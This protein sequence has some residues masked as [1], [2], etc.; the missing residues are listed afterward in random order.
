[1]P[2]FMARPLA[3]SPKDLEGA[4]VVI[5]GSSYVAGSEEYAG[6]SRADWMAAAKRVRQQS[7]RYLSG[8]VQEFDI[9]IFEHLKVVDYGDAE[10]PASCLEELTADN[11]LEAQAAVEQ[12]VNDVLAAGAIPIVIGQN[13]PCS[14][15]AIAKPISESTAGKVGMV[16]LDTHWDSEPI[17]DLTGDPRIAGSA[18]WKLK[19]YQNLDNFEPK[20][21][22]EIGERGMLEN[23]QQV[24]SYLKQGVN[25]YP[26]WKIR[27]ELGIEGLCEEIAHAY[28]DTEAVYV[29]FDMDVIG[30][31]GPVPGDIL[32][33]LA[34]PMGM[35]DY[36]VLRIANEVGRR[37]LTGMSF[38]CIPP[39]SNIVY[40]LITYII[41]FL[42]AGLLEGREEG[43]EKG[44]EE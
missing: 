22:V 9:D 43:R 24:R 39:G 14:S 31:A 18:N 19:T 21:L 10:V 27:R 16:S 6:V 41:M 13:S 5:I 25:F 44:R 32:G 26:M 36:E 42:M 15:Y 40:R 34:E 33:E 30:G 23:K 38:I 2:T 8:Y 28:D 11:I 35:T 1:T 3:T 7:N 12:K 20:N 29:H 37:G 4:D 17:D